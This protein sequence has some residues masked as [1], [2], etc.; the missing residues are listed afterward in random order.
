M[1]EILKPQ[2]NFDA[3]KISASE[4]AKQVA[5]D[6]DKALEFDFY[7]GIEPQRAKK[8]IDLLIPQLKMTDAAR[9]TQSSNLKKSLNGL[10]GNLIRNERIGYHTIYSRS[11]SGYP[12]ERY[13]PLKIGYRGLIAAIDGLEELGFVTNKKGFY[14]RQFS[15]GRKSRVKATPK[16]LSL[17]SDQLGI[18]NNDTQSLERER[19]ILRNVAGKD[20]GY[21]ETPRT[22]AM[23]N[24]L[25]RYNERLIKA[26]IRLNLPAETIE[27]SRIDPTRK[28]YHRVFQT[29]FEHGGR[30]YG[31]FWLFAPKELRHKILIN[32][33]TVTELD[34]SGHHIHMLYSWIGLIH[35]DV[36]GLGNDPYAIDGFD[37]V[38]RE[39]CKKAF[40]AI[41]GSGS[42]AGAL[43]SVRNDLRGKPEFAGLDYTLLLD[44]LA[45]KHDGIEG[46]FYT[47][48]SM[49]LQHEDSLITEFIIDEMLEREIIVLCIH[50]SFIVQKNY[51]DVL[52]DV[53]ARAWNSRGLKSIPKIDRKLPSELMSI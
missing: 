48:P 15:A 21:F 44:R 4:I 14:R 41:M 35:E 46:C 25:N 34:Y 28:S 45:K 31:P 13:N 9:S 8:A 6:L 37:N 51:E 53:M 52:L 47:N 43:T 18:T 30:Y 10:I 36:H 40:W 33:E 17:I 26:S 38:H 49:E 2:G 19:I 27:A 1:N 22:R 7:C 50:D 3:S 16:L 23:R 29:D 24:Q 11:H 5:L 32:D 12:P 42:R 20:I 39:I